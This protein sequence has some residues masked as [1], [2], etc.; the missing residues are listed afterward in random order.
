MASLPG[1]SLA[2]IRSCCPDPAGCAW[3]VSYSYHPAPIGR[4]PLLQ[5]LPGSILHCYLHGR[6]YSA[7]IMCLHAQPRPNLPAIVAGCHR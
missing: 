1:Q 2:A 7:G 6:R 5:P 3:V 4:A